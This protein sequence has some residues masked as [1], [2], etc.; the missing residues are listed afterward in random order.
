MLQRA[1]VTL[2]RVKSLILAR[3][4]HNRYHHSARAIRLGRDGDM[5]FLSP[6]S[7]RRLSR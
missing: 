2:S 3:T 1:K 4:L 7:N 5:V 6:R